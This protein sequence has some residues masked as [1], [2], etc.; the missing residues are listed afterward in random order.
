M[1]TPRII[2]YTA[3]ETA[4]LLRIAERTLYDWTKRRKIRPCR[5]SGR[6]APLRYPAS[7]IERL[8][9]PTGPLAATGA[10]A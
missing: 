4:A 8:A 6:G 7:E 9:A 2:V 3:K 1:T 5:M 10:R